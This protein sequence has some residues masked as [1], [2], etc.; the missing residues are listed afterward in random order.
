MTTSFRSATVESND[1]MVR[2]DGAVLDLQYAEMIAESIPHIVWTASPDGATTYFNRQGTAYTGHPREVTYR[3]NWVALVHS[4]DAERAAQAW[5]HATTTGTDY[6]LE[7]RIRRFDGAFRWHACRAVPLRDADGEIRLW[8]GTATDIEE[9]K[10]LELTLRHAEQ[11]ATQVVTLLQSIDA[12]TPIGFKMVDRDLRVT[13]INQTL[14]GIDGRSIQDCLGLTVSE[15]VPDLWPQ[16]EDVYRRAL[17]GET[18][19]NVDVSRRSATEPRRMQ[20]W[21]ASYYP[22]RVD[23]ETIGVGNVVVD[24][25]ERKEAEEFRAVVMDNMAEGLFAVDVDGLLT[26]LNPA[27]TSMLGWTED[28]L[29]GKPIHAAVHFQRADGTK[30]PAEDCCLLQVRTQGR[31][32]RI[33]D[34][35]F[36]RKDG[37]IFPVAY[38]SAPLRSGSLLQGVVV[39]FRDITEEKNERSA[40]KRELEALMWLGRIRDAIDENRLVLYSQPIVPLAGGRPSEELLLRMIGRDNEVILPG[41]FLPV[42]EKYGLIGEIDRWVVTQAVRLAATEHRVIEANLSASSIGASDLL[43][44]IEQ[45]IREAHADPANL[46]FEITET[47]LMHDI[48]VGEAFARGLAELGCGLALDD[49]GTGFGSFTYLKRLPI[50]HLKIDIDFVRDLVTHPNNLHVVKAIIS[51]ARAFGLKTI[52]EGVE[53]EQTLK[54][55][56][57]E[58]VDFAQG[59]H[60]GRPAPLRDV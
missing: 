4:E 27:A 41:S 26:Y 23:G 37:S 20:H 50:T 56:K 38:S 2:F 14:A 46:I 43:P 22:V 36:T 44:F 34:D 28:E 24:I 48:V 17:G 18:V 21:L 58:G 55:L 3:W 54:L 42:A 60:L 16:L 33:L 45:Q 51:L 47:A 40:A 31:S 8:I 11:N 13:R 32:I 1:A 35:A 7:Y 29:R 15:L 10:Q 53:D 12:A 57:D 52:A 5:H 6:S 19:S 9:Q 30:V 49:F 39:V 25:S 59:F